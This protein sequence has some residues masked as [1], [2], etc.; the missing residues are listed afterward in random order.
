LID[1][2][3]YI[4]RLRETNHITVL[5][6]AGK[7]AFDNSQYPFMIILRKTKKKER[8]KRNREELSQQRIST[9]ILWLTLNLVTKCFSP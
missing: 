9:E 5:I 6:N 4:N 8:K 2:I 3:H 1:V 7:K